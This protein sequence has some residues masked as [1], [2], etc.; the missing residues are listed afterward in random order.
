M[1]HGFAPTRSC[2]DSR[3]RWTFFVKRALIA[4]HRMRTLRPYLHAVAAV[5]IATVAGA[6]IRPWA[7]PVSAVFFPAVMVPAIYG[8]IGPALVSTVL[9]TLSLA[10]FFVPPVYSFQ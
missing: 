9:S 1:P 2:R 6:L 3:H 4:L 7:G 10:F 8:G 5:C